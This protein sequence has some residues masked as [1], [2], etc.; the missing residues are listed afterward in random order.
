MQQRHN[1]TGIIFAVVVFAMSSVRCELSSEGFFHQNSSALKDAIDDC[2]VD[3]AK[4]L[5]DKYPEL[6]NSRVRYGSRRTDTMLGY[7]L[8]RKSKEVV[9]YLV[10]KGATLTA[11]ET[12]M[13]HEIV[14][15][16]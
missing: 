5:I 11:T 15:Y 8:Y 4:S 16:L 6:V 13:L 3:I 7:A 1:Y 12:T 9:E 2:S 14:A 10:K